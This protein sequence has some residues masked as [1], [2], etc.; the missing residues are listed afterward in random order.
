MQE[1][2]VAVASVFIVSIIIRHVSVK[3]KKADKFYKNLG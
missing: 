2:I 1:F 3:R